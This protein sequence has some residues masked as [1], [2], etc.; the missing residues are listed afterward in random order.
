MTVKVILV[1]ATYEGGH[2]LS[3]QLDSLLV[4]TYRQWQLFVR[5]DGSQDA[6]LSILQ[7]Y[8]ALDDRIQLLHDRE[9]HLGV[10]ANF[11]RL[12]QAALL[13]GAEY[14]FFVDQDDDWLPH[15]IERQM[16]LLQHA[17]QRF[18][19]KQPILVYSDLWLMDDQSHRLTISFM[20]HQ[21]I[22]HE[23]D[24]AIR[25]LMTQNMVTGCSVAINRSLLELGLPIPE[26][27]VMHDW[28]FAL[29]ASATGQLVYSEQPL[30]YY[31]QHAKNQ[32]GAQQPLQALWRHSRRA[33]QGQISE[34]S[35]SLQQVFALEQRLQRSIT[36]HQSPAH[37]Y[38][39]TYCHIFRTP[40]PWYRR[41]GR[42]L[43]LKVRRQWWLRYGWFLLQ[44]IWHRD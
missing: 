39:K 29:L 7:H 12:L 16:Q 36:G 6:T 1:L 2:Y 13:H 14:I 10:V 32:I 28:W 19:R 34:F 21:H 35:R 42:L 44:V 3:Q 26:T 22:H 33:W 23:D 41:L 18:D 17:E 43:K 30:L 15:K 5:D 24:N 31:R 9:G 25:V 4:Q 8:A 20:T 38:L 37:F 40:M 27:A 11:E